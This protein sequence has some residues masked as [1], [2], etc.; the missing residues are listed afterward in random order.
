MPSH[1]FPRPSRSSRSS[2]PGSDSGHGGIEGTAKTEGTPGRSETPGASDAWQRERDAWQRER[3]FVAIVDEVAAR[4]YP[5]TRVAAVAARAG[6]DEEVF[7]AYFSNKEACLLAAFDS[8]T[9]QIHARVVSAYQAPS[10][11][12]RSS[13]RAAVGTLI[14]S[15][16]ARPEVALVYLR[17][18]AT[19]GPHS[20]AHHNWALMLYKQSL[21][22]MLRDAPVGLALSPVELDDTVQHI[23]RTM[24]ENLQTTSAKPTP[25]GHD[26]LLAAVLELLPQ[27]VPLQ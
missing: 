11:D 1:P 7:H 19:A 3:L 2:S 15:L 10:P 12:W 16:C 26:A 17:D 9:A 18:V 4:G 5:H 14:D 27:P 13:V 20:E 6:L 21:A 25:A 23:W 22:E 8:L 24:I